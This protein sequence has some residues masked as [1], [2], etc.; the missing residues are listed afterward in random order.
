MNEFH[1]LLNEMSGNPNDIFQKI[2]DSKFEPFLA[3]NKIPGKYTPKVEG[4]FLNIYLKKEKVASL[5]VTVLTQ[6][7]FDKMVDSLGKEQS[8][9]NTSMGSK[10]HFGANT[11]LDW[12][13]HTDFTR[14]TRTTR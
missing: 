8:K 5:S 3:Q 13:K 14:K 2:I 9:P 12:D 4:N 10:T 6:E 11:V 1:T 7:R